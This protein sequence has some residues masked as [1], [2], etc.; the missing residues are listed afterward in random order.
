MIFPM[1]NLTWRQLFSERQL[2]EIDFCRVYSKDF[3]HGT[4]GHNIR[5]VVAQM[6]ELLDQIQDEAQKQGDESNV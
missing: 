2:K 6:A 3:N 5:L 4:D 1:G